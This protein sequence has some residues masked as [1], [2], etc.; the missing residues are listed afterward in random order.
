[1]PSKSKNKG[2]TAEREVAKVLSKWFG[3][4]FK[5]IPNSGALRWN[6]AS[7]VYGDLLPPESFPG[8][9]ESKFYKEID[10][11]G[12]LRLT[13]Q[14]NNPLGWWLQ[15]V[16]DVQ[17]CYSE[18]RLALQP[19]L[20]FKANRRPRRIVIE[21]KLFNALRWGKTPGLGQVPHFCLQRAEFLGRVVVMD[22]VEFLGIVDPEAYA[23]AANASFPEC[24]GEP[25]G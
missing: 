7:F 19:V 25:R 10:L 12:L 9:I 15:V 5:R 18:L 22:L 14:E 8:I 23:Q 24:L 17:R 2:N 13:V 16:D 11:D 1:M 20:I 21:E 6:G 4:D 3:E